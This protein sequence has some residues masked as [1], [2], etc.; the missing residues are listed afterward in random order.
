MIMSE[1]TDEKETAMSD[2]K[3]EMKVEIPPK[4][5][6][7]SSKPSRLEY[8]IPAGKLQSAETPKFDIDEHKQLSISC[9]ADPLDY[10][11]WLKWFHEQHIAKTEAQI[12]R[13]TDIGET[14]EER[15]I[16]VDILRAK[17]RMQQLEKR[18]QEL[19][20][21]GKKKDK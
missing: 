1:I 6:K 10:F 5:K 17:K 12:S 7:K 13:F 21:K 8:V 11:K 15:V 9:F 16:E 18:K 20:K 2:P 14:V 4:S 19:K 3:S